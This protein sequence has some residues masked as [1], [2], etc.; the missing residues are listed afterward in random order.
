MGYD[1]GY[2]LGASHSIQVD[3]PVENVITM[4][5]AVYEYYGMEAP[6]TMD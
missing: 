4:C 3:T 6:Y 2:I 5:N 1:G